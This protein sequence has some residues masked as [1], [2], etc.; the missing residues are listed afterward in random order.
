MC[1]LIEEHSTMGDKAGECKNRAK[2][3]VDKLHC[4]TMLI[5]WLELESEDSVKEEDIVKRAEK[6]R[7]TIK[8]LC[9]P[10]RREIGKASLAPGGV[11][12]GRP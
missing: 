10:L 5:S 1:T 12:R 7:G 4:L 2:W 3:H 9:A 8:Q 6:A 11:C